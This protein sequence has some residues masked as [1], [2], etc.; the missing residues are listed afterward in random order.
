MFRDICHKDILVCQFFDL[1]LANDGCFPT[2][3]ECQFQ[4]G[5]GVVKQDTD[6]VAHMHKRV[7]RVINSTPEFL[8][9]VVGEMTVDIYDEEEE[10][11]ET[12]VLSCNQALL[13]YVGGHKIAI[14][15]GTKYFEIKQGPYFGRG[16][17][18]YNLEF[19]DGS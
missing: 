1:N 19:D 13:Q 9:V 15:K 8:Y 4:F 16:T 6:I 18:K 12:T 3:A 17:D 10:Y 5:Y 7:E 11:I 2:S 14:R